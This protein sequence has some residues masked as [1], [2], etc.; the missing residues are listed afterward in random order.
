VIRNRRRDNGWSHWA[1]RARISLQRRHPG[2]SRG[3]VGLTCLKS[4]SLVTVFTSP[5][6][7]PSAQ[8]TRGPSLGRSHGTRRV[9]Q[10]APPRVATT[11]AD[12]TRPG[13]APTG[14]RCQAQG[15]AGAL[16]EVLNRFEPGRV[17]TEPEVNEILRSIH[18]DFATCVASWSTTLPRAGRGPIP[19]GR[20]GANPSAIER[21]GDPGLG[22]RLAA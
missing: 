16:L 5:A 4:R 17:Y 11:R 19:R 2:R 15:R 9:E 13:S 18:E 6:S 10:T 12:K 21:Q 7:R 14:R 1:R 22:G 3:R 8:P 20:A